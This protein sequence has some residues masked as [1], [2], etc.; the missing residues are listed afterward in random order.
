[1]YKSH[2]KTLKLFFKVNNTTKF[3]ILYGE[4]RFTSNF[5]TF[6]CVNHFENYG[7]NPLGFL[8]NPF[9]NTRYP[10]NKK[11]KITMV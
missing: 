7:N 11:Y 9:G 10:K 8:M 5:E 2:N 6:S 4:K 1:M 3:Y